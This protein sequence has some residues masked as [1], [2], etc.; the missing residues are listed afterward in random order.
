M[1]KISLMIAILAVTSVLFAQT[2]DQR[3]S[4][5]LHANQ[6]NYQGDLGNGFLRFKGID[7][8]VS[9]SLGYYLSPSFDITAKAGWSHTHFQDNDGTYAVGHKGIA[10][11]M[12]AHNNENWKFYG[13]LWN[14][15]ANLKFKFNNGWLLKEE[16]T[17]APFAIGGV[18][19][20]RFES[21]AIMNHKHEGTYQNLALYYGAG[22]NVRLSERLNMVLE[23]GIYNPMTDVYDGITP[24]TV[25]AWNG[26]NNMGEKGH[27]DAAKSNDEFLQYSLGFTY[28]L[29]KRADA[30]N[31]GVAD[32]KD[33]C[34]NTPA[35]V[36]VDENGCP[37]DTDGDGVADYLD[38]CPKVAGKVKGCPDTDGDGI[39]DS[40][41]RCPKVAGLKALQ[42]C[43]DSDDDKDGVVNLKDKC[44]NTPRGVRVDAKGCPI[45]I[46][47]DG[48]GV[49]DSEDKCP[50][51]AGSPRT[52]GCPVQEQLNAF[53]RDVYF[54]TNSA[55]LKRESYAVLDQVVRLLQKYNG[56]YNIAI[57]GYTDSVGRDSYNLKLSEK[58]A[59]AVKNYLVRK[60]VSASKLSSRGYGEANPIAT[61]KTKEGRA[62][63]R[64][65]EIVV[66]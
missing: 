7:P 42:G 32:R 24:E 12:G 63:N 31:D 66:E 44:P 51:V 41:D 43:P 1:K 21:V 25:P 61:N 53:A 34:P 38:K 10:D 60:G 57:K 39:I 17:F 11:L 3:W 62:K 65:T 48:D 27:G 4:V 56:N 20:T 35:G 9:L 52:Q 50:N 19:V 28:N 6:T 37:I 22:L 5:G 55:T 13:A 23:A 46:D 2:K 59:A 33:K 26:N 58:R 16:A 14:A 47:T 30:D 45:A 49:I 18:G 64:R 36:A 29:G 8:G 40:K 54:N 15:S